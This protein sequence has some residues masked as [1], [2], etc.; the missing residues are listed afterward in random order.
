MPRIGRITATRAFG[1]EEVVQGRHAGRV[2]VG[3]KFDPII[4][5]LDAPL[6]YRKTAPS[7][8]S[9]AKHRADQPNHY[10]IDHFHNGQWSSLP[11]PPTRENYHFVQPLGADEWLLVHGRAKGNSDQ[12]AHVYDSAGTLT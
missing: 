12:D 7:G 6:D 3:S 1:L 2:A 10:R 5:S 8:A 9:F 11:F 4:L